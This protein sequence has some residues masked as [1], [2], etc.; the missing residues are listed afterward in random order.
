MH[1]GGGG[2]TVAVTL[3]RWHGAGCSGALLDSLLESIAAVRVCCHCKAAAAL[4][5]AA[6]GLG[7]EKG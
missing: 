6:R 3:W 4:K 2:T 7:L 1:A 5:V